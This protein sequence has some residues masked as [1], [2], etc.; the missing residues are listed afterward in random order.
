MVAEM[1]TGSGFCCFS[2]PLRHITALYCIIPCYSILLYYC[3]TKEYNM[4]TVKVVLRNNN[5]RVDGTYTIAIRVTENRKSVFKSTGIAVQLNQFRDKQDQWVYRHPD[6]DIFNRKIEELRKANLETSFSA[7]KNSITFFSAV[8]KMI[9]T[10]EQQQKVASFNRLTTNLRYLKE[11]WGK[12]I[13]LTELNREWVNKYIAYR[14]K[15]GNTESTIKKNLQDLSVCVNNID[16]VSVVNYFKRMTSTLKP[17]PIKRQGLQPDEIAKLENV[18]LSGLHDVARDM[19]L[20]SYYT[21][22]MRF[23]NVATFSLDLINNNII[24]YRMNKGQK[25]REIE[26]HP[27]LQAIINKYKKNGTLYLFP[28]VKEKHDVWNKKQI[29]GNA[30]ALVRNYLLAAGALAGITTK[31]HMHQARHSFAV[32]A[33]HKGKALGVLKDAL[34]HTS[35]NTTQNYAKSLS[36]DYIN[37]EINDMY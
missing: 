7:K 22:G 1:L 32:N 13:P 16:D 17:L 10:Y 20:F 9:T 15:L 6:A 21:H 30:N 33:L 18:S 2:Y 8:K 5:K 11:A 36:D 24:R 14:K 27:K 31:I 19:Y 12:D 34:G 23:E 37:R 3:C 25:V 26:I 4:I 28:V 35:F 29:I